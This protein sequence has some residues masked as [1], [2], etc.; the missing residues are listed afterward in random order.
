[1]E[2]VNDGA[3]KLSEALAKISTFS[4]RSRMD[5]KSVH[6]AGFKTRLFSDPDTS[7]RDAMEIGASRDKI[8]DPKL[9]EQVMSK[10]LT[11]ADRVLKLFSTH[12]N[13]VKRIRL[14]LDLG[15]KR[16]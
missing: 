2:H 12:P 6:V 15:M 11:T 13:A 9:V 10:K 4:Q 3:R 14:L 7:Q 16:P 5:Q 8:S 1:M